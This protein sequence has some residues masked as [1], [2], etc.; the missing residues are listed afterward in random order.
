MPDATVLEGA[1]A[2]WTPY[3]ASKW[4]E[5]GWAKAKPL[6]LFPQLRARVPRRGE[7]HNREALP[8]VGE[9]GVHSIAIE[10][11]G[12]V[13]DVYDTPCAGLEEGIRGGRYSPSMAF[14]P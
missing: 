13:T 5:G 4:R 8:S 12:V 10:A 6:Q 2:G 9:G 1:D 7:E 14:N 11:E 3:G